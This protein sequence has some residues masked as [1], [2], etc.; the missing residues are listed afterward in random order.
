MRADNEVRTRINGD[1]KKMAASVLEASG[2]TL[3]DV[4]RH[5]ITR[6]A[7]EKKYTVEIIPNEMTVKAIQEARE[8]KLKSFDSVEDML[9]S[10]HAEA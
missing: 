6:I 7:L 9:K 1:I 3:S 2:L 5:T 8:G 4:I 10:L